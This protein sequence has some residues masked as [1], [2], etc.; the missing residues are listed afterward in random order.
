MGQIIKPDG[1]AYE[2]LSR[3]L[4]F[5]IKITLNSIN[6]KTHEITP[7]SLQAYRLPSNM[8]DKSMP[9]DKDRRMAEIFQEQMSRC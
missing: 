4:M 9:G 6:S 8:T 2:N 7:N 1:L 3:F 5:L